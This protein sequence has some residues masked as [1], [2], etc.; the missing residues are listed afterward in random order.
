MYRGI[1]TVVLSSGTMTSFWID[2]W[3]SLGLLD[4]ALPALFSNCLEPC[5]TIAAAFATRALVLPL[6]ERLSPAASDELATLVSRLSG[7]HLGA[8]PDTRRL[9]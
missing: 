6:W 9:A 8:A 5:I 2:N 7:L 4:R 1:T 3:T